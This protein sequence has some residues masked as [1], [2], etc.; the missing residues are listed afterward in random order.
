MNDTAKLRRANYI[1]T[2]N[3]MLAY[4]L[5]NNI[6][7]MF[8][9]LKADGIKMDDSEKICWTHLNNALKPITGYR[10]NFDNNKR[11]QY[12]HYCKLVS[13]V[14]KELLAKTENDD[15]LLYKFYNYIKL[16]PSKLP[17]FEVSASEEVDAFSHLFGGSN[18]NNG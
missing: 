7:N 2:F 12:E 16:F 6:D 14:I 4:I 17:E 5:K 10:F 1:G 11:K 3:N 9:E 18:D 13:I 8:K 15:M